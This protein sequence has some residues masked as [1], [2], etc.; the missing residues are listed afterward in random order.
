MNI[1]VRK[2][3]W[4]HR[5]GNEYTVYDITNEHAEPE[6]RDKYPIMISYVGANG[7]RWSK[8]LKDFMAKMTIIPTESPTFMDSLDKPY[9]QV[10]APGV[11]PEL[12][13]PKFN[14]V[15]DRKFIPSE[16]GVYYFVDTKE[17]DDVVRVT[18]AARRYITD[19]LLQ[20]V[21]GQGVKTAEI[22]YGIPIVLNTPTR[23]FRD[24]IF[25]RGMNYLGRAFPQTGPVIL[26]CCDSDGKDLIDLMVLASYIR[27]VYLTLK[28]KEPF[29][30]DEEL[31]EYA[32]AITSDFMRYCVSTSLVRPGGFGVHKTD[33]TVTL[34]LQHYRG[35]SNFD[36]YMLTLARC[37]NSF[38]FEGN[39]TLR[40]ILRL[41]DEA[42]LK[43][44]Q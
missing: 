22:M 23:V 24:G 42:T 21:G 6:N 27:Y 41:Y 3:K 31:T 13:V 14:V 33:L 16:Y 9:V 19:V 38:I 29:H 12:L 10:P 2:T 40:A 17:V 15:L 32:Y 26:G 25:D 43:G 36:N 11:K 30:T 5:N 1:P 8:T 39:E 7:K 44:E 37:N 20:V 18:E 34:V 28:D 35:V 4:R